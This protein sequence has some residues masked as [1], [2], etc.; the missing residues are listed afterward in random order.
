[1][2]DLVYSLVKLSGSRVSQQAVT[3]LKKV[4]LGILDTMR[5]YTILTSVIHKMK[6][7]NSNPIDPCIFVFQ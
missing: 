4:S 3:G 7:Q 6:K 5:R 2:A 1:M